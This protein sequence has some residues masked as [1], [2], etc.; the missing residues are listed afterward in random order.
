ME[1]VAMMIGNT[2]T[3]ICT[4]ALPTTTNINIA[5]WSRAM[6][7]S[8]LNRAVR[9]LAAGPFGSHFFSASASVDGN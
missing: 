4:V 5:N 8:V 7:K 6:W 2:V 9:M 3:G 1:E